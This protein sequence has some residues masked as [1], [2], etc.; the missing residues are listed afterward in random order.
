MQIQ[1][2]ECD[3]CPEVHEST[4]KC[5]GES[6]VQYYKVSSFG[7]F[8]SESTMRSCAEESAYIV[9]EEYTNCNQNN[10]DTK[11]ATE[12]FRASA[13]EQDL[14]NKDSKDS[15]SCPGMSNAQLSPSHNLL[16]KMY[17]IFINYFVERSL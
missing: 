3:N 11:N 7:N 6:C 4:K 8:T 5:E 1:C 12:Y 16:P 15:I 10:A 14:C 13:C 9:E 2:Y 17:L